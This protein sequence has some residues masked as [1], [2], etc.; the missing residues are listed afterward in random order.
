MSLKCVGFDGEPHR[1]HGGCVSFSLCLRSEGRNVYLTVINLK[2]KKEKKSHNLRSEH[3]TLTYN[4]R[5]SPSGN[6][7]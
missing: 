7:K 1:E 3:L 2:V 6:L 4:S 5:C